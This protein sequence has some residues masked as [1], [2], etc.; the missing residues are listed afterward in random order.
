MKDILKII[1]EYPVNKD[2]EFWLL[3]DDLD[4]NYDINNEEDNQKIIELLRVAK[5]Y[6]NEI[7]KNSNAKILIFVRDDVRDFI[8]SKYNDSAKIFNSYEIV[9]NW[10]NHNLSLSDENNNPLKENGK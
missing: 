1:I 10:Y 7:F 6:N 4:V 2:L 8:I 5:H 3:F 9:I